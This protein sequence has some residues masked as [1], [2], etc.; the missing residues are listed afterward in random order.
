M[1]LL[2]LL[3]ALGLTAC[4]SDGAEAGAALLKF[5]LTDQGCCPGQA[6]VRAGPVTFS[7][8]NGGTTQVTE[9]ELHN[10]SGS[11]SASGRTSCPGFRARSRSI[12]SQ[13]STSSC[14]PMGT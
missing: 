9:L 2:A 11:S 8:T 10:E 1:L 4:G 7:V 5:T 3:A 12:W 14:A 6:S 13:A